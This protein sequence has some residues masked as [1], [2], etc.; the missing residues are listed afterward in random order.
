MYNDVIQG[1][2]IGTRLSTMQRLSINSFIANGHKYHLYAYTDL[3]D[4]PPAAIIKDASTILPASMVFQNH[5]H[6]TYAAFSD[7]FRYKLLLTHGGWW[8]DLDCVCL[9]YFDFDT[10]YVFSSEHVLNGSAVYEEVN[11]GVIKAPKGAEILE[12][13]W[14]T[15]RAKDPAKASW[16]ELGPHI[17][18]DA[19]SKFSLSQYVKPAATFC[20]LPP[21]QCKNI[22]DPGCPLVFGKET[23]TVHLWNELWRR[24]NTNP[25]GV[26]DRNCF[27][28]RLK[29]SYLPTPK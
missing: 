24:S 5:R 29:A 27:Y 13:A 8:A 12:Y 25:D 1:L 14:A 2:W 18:R 7:L 22:V 10:D 26:F 23:Y 4:V 15:S 6:A 9:R 19:V 16:D 21:W 3:E 20:P 17:V 28:E 11:S